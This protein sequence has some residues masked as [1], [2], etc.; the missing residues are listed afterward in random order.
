MEKID[1]SKGYK[2]AVGIVLIDKDQRVL[3]TRRS[4]SLNF[5]RRA[6]VLP[7]GHVDPG[8]DLEEAALRELHEECG[9]HLQTGETSKLK[10]LCVFESSTRKPNNEVPSSSHAIV[11]F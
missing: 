11:F 6:W 1:A 10:A 7:G 3:L 5:F 4:D 9:I 2:A 8:E